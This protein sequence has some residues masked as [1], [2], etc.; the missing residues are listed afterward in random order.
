MN[1][2]KGALGEY[3]ELSL[4]VCL[5]L[6]LS[7]S[8]SIFLSV[9]LSC[10]VCVSLSSVPPFPHSSSTHSYKPLICQSKLNL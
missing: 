1:T 8:L 4:S 9:C 5:C 7:V 2:I 10:C 3:N 6:S